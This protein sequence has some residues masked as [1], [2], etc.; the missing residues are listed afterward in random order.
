MMPAIDGSPQNT[1]PANEQTRAAMA[2]PLVPGGL[3]GRYG[4]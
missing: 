3:S 1:S 2:L 4:S